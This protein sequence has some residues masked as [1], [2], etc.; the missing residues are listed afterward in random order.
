M[1]LQPENITV[2]ITVDDSD[3]KRAAE[4]VSGMSTAERKA[5]EGFRAINK[6]AQ[7]AAKSVDSLADET[8]QIKSK[9]VSSFN[10]ELQKTGS[11]FSSLSGVVKG[12]GIAI[13]A[14]LS[15]GA[16]VEFG[17]KI[18]NVTAEYQRLNTALAQN[19]GNQTEANQKF[20]ELNALA[21]VTP[22]SVKELTEAYI[23]FASRGIKLTN[24]EI[25]KLGDVASSQGKSIDQLTEAVLDAQTGEFERLKEFGIRAT[26][27][28]GVVTTSF[29]GVETQANLTQEGVKNLIVAMGTYP[30]VAG[31]ME[32][33]SETLGG[34]L[35]TLNDS[36]D[37]LLAAV[38][39]QLLPVFSGGISILAEFADSIR[40][41]L[42]PANAA[43]NAFDI[44]A[45]SVESLQN[46]L[47][48]LIDRY[49]KLKSATDPASQKELQGVMNEI[50]RLVP[51]AISQQDKYGNVL[52]IS[53]EQLDAF[54]K[55][56]KDYKESLRQTGI[57]ET[58]AEIKRLQ[59]ELANLQGELTNVNAATL[60]LEKSRQGFLSA[61]TFGAAGKSEAQ[62]ERD[63]QIL[64]EKESLN[65]RKQQE[66]TSQKLIEQE[67][68]LR[69]LRGEAIPKA[70]AQ[71]E[72]QVSMSAE[73]R[74]KAAKEA[75]DAEK[76]LQE[77]LRKVRQQFAQSQIADE[78]ERKRQ[79]VR[80][81]LENDK[82]DIAQSKASAKTKADLIIA[83]TQKAN[84]EIGKINAEQRKEIAKKELDESLRLAE[85]YAT[86]LSTKQKELLTKG[87][88]TQDD[89][90][91]EQLKID[92]QTAE[93]RLQIQKDYGVLSEKEVVAAE[94]KV[95]EARLA[96]AEKSIAD[97]KKLAE[98]RIELL[99]K[100]SVND[101]L[102]AIRESFAKE[103]SENKNNIAKQKSLTI[104]QA[105]AEFD[106]LNKS[107]EEQ[108][109]VATRFR[110]LE[111][112]SR[113]NDLSLIRAYY[114]EK[115]KLAIDYYDK[116]IKAAEGNAARQAELEA[117]KNRA[118][119]ELQTKSNSETAGKIADL[120]STVG[121]GA[122][123]I[124]G[125]FS[126]F[127]SQLSQNE[128][129]AFDE[130]IAR[131]NEA[132]K[133]EMEQLD[134][135]KQAKELAVGEDKIRL[136][137]Q[138]ENQQRRINAE[139][140]AEADLQRQKA[141]A[142]KRA[143][144]TQKR[145]KILEIVINTAAG[146]AKAIAESP[147]TFGLP[148]SAFVAAAGA[149]QIATVAAQ[150]F[151]KGTKSV[152]GGKEGMDS[153]PAILMPG[154]MVIPTKTAQEYKPML[155][156]IF[157]KRITPSA[158]NLALEGLMKPNAITVAAGVDIKP[159]IKAIERAPKVNVNADERGFSVY[160]QEENRRSEYLNKRYSS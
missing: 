93:L 35:S 67:A 31:S 29:K 149:L 71:K 110:N 105:K 14:A 124:V 17:K 140:K 24:D 64:A 114:S 99:S 151:A 127:L 109:S 96:I 57:S 95:A 23:K 62:T 80:D 102:N 81:N 92:L 128:I 112:I 72:E 152:K 104:D 65:I 160:L 133:T 143:F 141:D 32:K 120:L 45:A 136:D 37:Q 74:A 68:K 86:Q 123:Q 106:L 150:K 89:F 40:Q 83:E 98:S 153:V 12:A 47:N 2:K 94:A 42:D 55:S 21:A 126:S 113:T 51:L 69:Q 48:P 76:K 138:I 129:A 134:Q 82:I 159:L 18:F 145:L 155:N 91:N 60:Q 132:L 28:N 118:I 34:R 20:K 8:S 144:E 63:A 115:T 6:E 108:G 43:Q 116:L 131:R 4:R 142:Q 39:E 36:F 25:T 59:A 70:E 111:E 154:E 33:Q 30:G 79:I 139:K 147:V 11:G 117:E 100:G 41:I 13:A 85:V 148:F 54:V 121:Q 22:F 49:N 90:A 77:E 58:E 122:N 16:V 119:S 135:L 1:A 26:K 46:S 75:A 44:Q 88:I 5:A 10:S 73:A 146:V 27:A 158:A 156:A 15:V 107:L 38:G 19:L 84:A 97:E 52:A 87:L 9:N 7:A 66:A 103:F 157:D 56:Q 61:I 137:A 125:N 101:R 50:G 53:K 3:L 78:F 130:Q